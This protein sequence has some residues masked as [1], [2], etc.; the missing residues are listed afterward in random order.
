MSNEIV[1]QVDNPNGWGDRA[2][3][4]A[5]G[6]RLKA[7]LPG[8][9]AMSENQAMALAQYAHL[10]DTNPFNGEVYGF[11]N[12]GKFTL[13]TGYKALVRWAKRQ[14]DFTDR[15]TE[16]TTEERKAHGVAADSIAVKCH[17]LREDKKAD[18][19]F[20]VEC[21]AT[22]A[23]ALAQVSITAVGIVAK[24]EMHGDKYQIDPPKGWTWLQVAEKRALKNAL[25][26]AYGMP[27][28]KEI[29]R[30]L[31][32]ASPSKGL[33]RQERIDLLRGEEEEGID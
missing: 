1:I 12:K 2:E 32:E 5:S 26:R 11:D 24:K 19:K 23:E 6:R 14:C 13:V 9:E 20:F 33:T 29:Q 3:I 30:D 28:P 7:L 27:S 18:I 8:G 15:Y 21:G 22:F 4:A 31:D 10:T 16:L 25:N 17:I